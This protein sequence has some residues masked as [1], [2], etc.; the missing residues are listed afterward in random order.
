MKHVFIIHSHITFYMALAI[1]K[2]CQLKAESIVLVIIFNAKKKLHLAAVSPQSQ[3]IEISLPRAVYHPHPLYKKL[4]PPALRLVPMFFKLTAHLKSKML[5]P[6]CTYTLYTPDIVLEPR[7][8]FAAAPNCRKVV[9]M[10]EG[11]ASYYPSY[12]NRYTNFALSGNRRGSRFIPYRLGHFLNFLFKE[13][14]NVMR[15][16]Y[17]EA[18]A[19]QQQAYVFSKQALT[20]VFFKPTVIPFYKDP[21][22]DLAI[23]PAKAAIFFMIGSG[24]FHDWLSDE[25]E[26]YKQLAVVFKNIAAP[27]L[28]LK[29]HFSNNAVVR[30]RVEHA[31]KLAA[32]KFVPLPDALPSEQLFCQRQNLKVYG[33]RSSALLYARMLSK[34]AVCDY[35]DYFTNTYTPAFQNIHAQLRSLYESNGIRFATP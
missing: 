35:D 2:F 17:L 19:V 27:K 4:V 30:S 6:S 24:N 16:R 32:K 26:F 22:I 8:F 7:R 29:Y 9:Y 21:T 3:I 10:E 12:F 15:Y 25:R 18:R 33:I 1:A 5:S 14:F 28:Y 31:L 13:T 11:T 34:A 23:I 20:A